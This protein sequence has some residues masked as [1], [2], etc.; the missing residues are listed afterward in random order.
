[1]VRT[2]KLD[3][4]AAESAATRLLP[5]H[6]AAL[7]ARGLT[8]P[9]ITAAGLRSETSKDKLAALLKWK[10]PGKTLAPAIVI[11][12]TGADG[13]NG[14]SRVRPDIPR[15]DRNGKAVK[16]ESPRGEPNRVYLPPGIAACLQDTAQELALTEGEFKALAITQELLPAVGLVGI[17]GWKEKDH[18]RLLPELEAVAWRGRKVY[19]IPD[20]DF[21]TK[22]GADDFLATQG[23]NGK[24]ALRKLL[25][26]AEDP[27]P[28]DAESLKEA[29][30]KLDPASEAEAFLNTGQQDGVFRLRFWRS[31]WHLWS[32][33]R[34]VELQ[35][36]EVRGRLITNLNEHYH[37]LTTSITA[38][39]LDQL[40][41]QSL[42]SFGH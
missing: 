21:G 41:A 9:T 26:N 31:G 24:A 36:S 28:V 40:K 4:A 16:Y 39:V 14:Y 8:D 33:G 13:S 6:H 3:D 5:H 38:N 37:H 10:R 12:F 19:L 18:Q 27:P 22:M 30:A 1:M 7:R 42:L 29:A 15:R 32:R 11:P 25:D 20:S 2:G 34:Y 23:A 17:G 35:P